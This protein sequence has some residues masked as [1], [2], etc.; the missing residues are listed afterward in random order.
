MS[1]EPPPRPRLALII[2]T[3]LGAA[4]L[5]ALDSNIVATALPTIAGEMKGFSRLAWVT[6]AYIVTSTISSIIL[7]KLSDLYGRRPILLITIGL[8]VA[9]SLLCGAAQSVEQLI[10]FRAVQGLGGGGILSIVFAVLGDLVPPIERSKYSGYFSIVFASGGVLG[11]L[12][13]GLI[14]DHWSWRW[15]FLINLPLGLVVML[16][17]SHALRIPKP[18]REVHI[19]YSGA[20]VLSV[21]LAAFM[22]GLEQSPTRGWRDGLVLGLFAVAVIGLAVF[23]RVEQKAR[24]PIIPLHLFRSRLVICVSMLAML[25]GAILFALGLYFAL[26]FQDVRFVS[27][28]TSGLR[29]LP[30]VIAMTLVA[31]V[32]GRTMARTGRYR[33]YPIGGSALIVVGMVLS[34]TV[35]VSTSYLRLGFAL[36]IVG[37]GLGNF[38]LIS[39]IAQNAAGPRDMGV[40]SAL[41]TFFRNL[42]GAVGLAIYSTVFTAVVK[43][44]LVRR[45]PAGESPSLKI[46]RDPKS[47]RAASAPIR[48]AVQ[49]SITDGVSTVFRIAVGV[50]I[51][52]LVIS[53]I[54]PEIPMRRTLEMPG[55]E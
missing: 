51:L 47:L 8:F 49:R 15:I 48:T 16:V 23:I 42:G 11:P 18:H 26:F 28:T 10:A 4:F 32:A 54:M 52:A 5:S 44:G 21:M 45:L 41:Q 39:S 31:L 6:T 14:V 38:V 9:G 7:A 3:L 22:I 50:A 1:S 29:L 27:P 24:E 46:I 2:S 55:T 20:L 43:D 25:L 35:T 37:L 12:L 17:I 19:D 30:Q 53:V 13:G 36:A 40:I 33:W 34:S